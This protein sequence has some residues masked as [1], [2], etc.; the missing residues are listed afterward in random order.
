LEGLTADEMVRARNRAEIEAAH[1]V[2]TF[3]T[4]AD[5]IGMFSTYFD[6]PTM[7]HHWLEPYRAATADD[8]LH[9]A[10]K[11]LIPENRVTSLF[12]PEA[13]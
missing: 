10:R 9:A 12:V 11:Y 13:R 2:E 3:D 5:L 6:D 8:L 1:Q 7:V 4:R